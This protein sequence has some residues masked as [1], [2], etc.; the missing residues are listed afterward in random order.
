MLSVIILSLNSEKFIKVCLDS[1][2]CQLKSEDEVISIDNGS[3]DQTVNLIKDNYPQVRLIQNKINFGAAR[4]RNQ[5]IQVS[6]GD[7]I[8]TLDCDIVLGEGFIGESFKVLDNVTADIGMIQPKVLGIDRK[9]V[10]SLGIFLSSW[11]RR[12]YD[13]KR[14]E[15]TGPA[16]MVFGACSAA[17]LYRRSMLE[18]VKEATGYFDERFFFLVED[19]DLAW[20]AQKRGFKAIYAPG[21]VCYH[22]GDSSSTNKKLRQYLCFRNRLYTIIKNEGL[23]R[24]SMKILPILFYDLPRIIYLFFTNPLL[25][26]G[27]EDVSSRENKEK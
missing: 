12:F 21:A 25:T 4:A 8:L 22:S 13:I 14:E 6:R 20:R 9:I 16:G 7:W 1:V 5:G 3:N 19:V 27:F 15:E 23:L 18:A 10:Y 2:L 26:K 11:F 17:A 24:Y